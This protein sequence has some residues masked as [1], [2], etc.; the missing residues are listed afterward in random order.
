LI[1]ELE[2]R[3]KRELL[4]AG[5]LLFG[6]LVFAGLLLSYG[7]CGLLGI[8]PEGNVTKSVENILLKDP[9]LGEVLRGNSYS[10][11]IVKVDGSPV[12][13]CGQVKCMAK[14]IVADVEFR[15]PVL[16]ASY[17][18]SKINYYTVKK[19]SVTVNLDTERIE[20]GKFVEIVKV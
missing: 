3:H 12:F 1:E 2:K 7:L 18:G 17:Y 11:S 5:A 20:D 6:Y 14:Y 8:P 16:V 15:E 10:I 9:K 19:I 4:L 13:T